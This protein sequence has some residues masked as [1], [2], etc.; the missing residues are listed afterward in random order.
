ME[1][2]TY[3][4]QSFVRQPLKVFRDSYN[5][6]NVIINHAQYPDG[7]FQ[8]TYRKRE[9]CFS[10][11]PGIRGSAK[12]A[13]AFVNLSDDDDQNNKAKKILDMGFALNKF[14][15]KWKPIDGLPGYAIITD[16]KHDFSAPIFRW[17][18]Y[19]MEGRGFYE[20]FEECERKARE[21]AEKNDE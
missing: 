17:T 18:N 15:L 6:C 16:S 14:G 7:V 13:T 21:H 3:T 10:H 20:T 1:K 2:K 9:A 4:S 11:E 5:G 12:T 8:L 19:K